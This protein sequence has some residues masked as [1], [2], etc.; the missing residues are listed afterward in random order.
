[1]PT[2]IQKANLSPLEALRFIGFFLG[3][4][5]GLACSYHPVHVNETEP[6]VNDQVVHADHSV[7]TNGC[8]FPR[9]AGELSLLAHSLVRCKSCSMPKR[10]CRCYKPIFSKGSGLNPGRCLN[11]EASRRRR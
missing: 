1:M 10:E 8:C 4:R 2:R 9:Q 7:G 6:M 3:R 11:T 5:Q